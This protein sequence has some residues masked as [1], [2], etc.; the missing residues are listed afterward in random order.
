MNWYRQSK[1]KHL[2]QVVE[3]SRFYLELAGEAVSPLHVTLGGIEQCRCDYECVR[4]TFPFHV[5]ELVASGT[6]LVELGGGLHRVE[7]GSVYSYGP[8]V[9][10][11]IRNVGSGIMTKYFVS[12]QG[13]EAARFLDVAGLPPAHIARVRNMGLVRGMFDSIVANGCAGGPRVQEV[14]AHL[15]QALLFLLSGNLVPHSPAGSRALETFQRARNLMEAEFLDLWRLDDVA[16][17]CHVAPAYLCRLFK[18]F[19][20]KTIHEYLL[21]LKMNHAAGL[22]LEGDLLVK[23]VAARVNYSDPYQFSRVFTRVIGISPARF[24]ALF[25]HGV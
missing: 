18:R 15:L 9:P 12:F 11:R 16:E 23:E 4:E 7:A 6:G 20:Q 24:A 14:C 21:E 2:S 5:L 13:T 19:E 8:G 1:A 25:R 22:L 10:H 3:A 17:R